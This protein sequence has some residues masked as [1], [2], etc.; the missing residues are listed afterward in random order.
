MLEVPNHV[1]QAL[2]I[3]NAFSTPH[4]TPFLAPCSCIAMEHCPGGDLK[5]LIK[6]KP[7]K[8][9]DAEVC[10]LAFQ[11]ASGIRA[12]HL[13]GIAHLDIKTANILLDARNNAKVR[14]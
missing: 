1:L 14:L 7:G 11:I 13:S 12:V 6:T 5:S 10:R 3:E 4:P 9:T 2:S 8:L